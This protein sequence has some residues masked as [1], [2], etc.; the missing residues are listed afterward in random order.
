M[1]KS[2]LHFQLKIYKGKGEVIW[3][4]KK[5]EPLAPTKSRILTRAAG[6][7]SLLKK[8]STSFII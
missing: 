1:A 6:N 4:K 7:S 5:E 2:L 8:A 3:N